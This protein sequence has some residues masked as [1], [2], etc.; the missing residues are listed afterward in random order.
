[1]FK[2][3]G[4]FLWVMLGC[5]KIDCQEKVQRSR[6]W[7]KFVFREPDLP[8]P[9]S[10]QNTGDPQMLTQL[11]TGPWQVPGRRVGI[12]AT[13]Q[14]KITTPPPEG[15]VL[16]ISIMEM[17]DLGPQTSF[18]ISCFLMVPGAKAS[19]RRSRSAHGT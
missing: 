4:G 13:D 18:Y 16:R 14:L 5:S 1:M 10:E 15:S 8:E 2:G 11:D 19:K 9:S 17:R 6:E 7:R 12:R 3:K